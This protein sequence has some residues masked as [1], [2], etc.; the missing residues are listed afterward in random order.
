MKKVRSH[1]KNFFINGNWKDAQFY[2][3]HLFSK[4][5]KFVTI[6]E[7]EF[8]AMAA[9][10][11]LGSKYPVVS[12]RNGATSAAKDIR[13]QYEWFDSFDNIVICFDGDEAGQKAASQV[14][15]IF[16]GKAKVFKHLDGMKDACDICLLVCCYPYLTV[17]EILWMRATI[18]ALYLCKLN[19]HFL[20]VLLFVHHKCLIHLNKHLQVKNKKNS[21]LFLVVQLSHLNYHKYL[22]Q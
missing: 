20:Y 2:G 9:Y 12:V 7:G 18:P 5:G 14:A 11:M 15:E 3:Q 8:D 16:G 4:G 17:Y 6:V 13:K 22:M 19:H 10:Q 1:D 21:F